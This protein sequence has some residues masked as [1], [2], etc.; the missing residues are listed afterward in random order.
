MK[1]LATI[2]GSAA[3]LVAA[4]IPAV[5]AGNN[6]GNGTTGAFSSNSCTINNTSNV[7]VN[8]VNDAKIT[9]NV[10][11]TVNSG[12][13]D[14]N[15]N[16]LGGK[17]LT[18]NATLNT[19]VSTV[20]NINT[21]NITGGPALGGNTGSN[22]ITGAGMGALV[23]GYDADTAG[24]SYASNS[25]YINNAQRVGVDN[26]NTAVV[27]SNVNATAN[28]GYNDANG[29]TGPGDVLAGAASMG[30]A[31]NTHVND[32]LT[33]VTA[34]AGTTGGNLAG[35]DT[36]GAFSGNSVTLNNLSD[37][38]VRNWNDMLVKNDVEA[39]VNSGYNDANM[40]TLGGDILSGPARGGVGVNT[41]GNIN[42]TTVEAAMGGFSNG[43]QNGITGAGSR[44]DTYLNNAQQIV[45]DNM[46]N[47]CMSHNS[48]S[49]N[50]GGY[51]EPWDLGVFNFVDASADVG[52]NDANMNTAGGQTLGSV[53]ELV[54]SV[55]T[56]INDTLTVVRQ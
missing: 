15:Y 8:N 52:G 26:Q 55:L 46:N 33:R 43:G 3:L 6:C 54:Q 19:T 13:N 32:N 24:G 29:N 28:T 44:N 10:T 17:I 35:N 34:G 2:V 12:H 5:A 25:V 36:T 39:D 49:V 40:N 51:C 18:G 16:T 50:N 53:A 48:S 42:T 45:V 56:H 47:K 22:Y 27:E 30:V 23:G 37:V 4:V 31:V 9:N 41:E 38:L 1:K 7:T 11:T 14:A 20:A 21:T